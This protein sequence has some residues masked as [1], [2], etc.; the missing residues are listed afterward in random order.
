MGRWRLRE[1]QFLFKKK[2]FIIYLFI[3][4]HATRISLVAQTVG[5]VPAMRETWLPSL[6][7]EDP[8][9]KEIA[10]HSS[11]L[12]LE[13]PWTEAPGGLQSQARRVRDDL[14]TKQPP[15]PPPL[16]PFTLKPQH[17]PPPSRLTFLIVHLTSSCLLYLSRLLSSMREDCLAHNRG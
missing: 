5:S 3:F 12:A 6:G 10:T 11:I 17:P 7:W 16:W 4:G 13:I 2:L 8:L 15:P 14:A 9:E 1:V